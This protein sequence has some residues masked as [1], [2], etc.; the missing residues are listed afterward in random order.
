MSHTQI[1]EPVQV[2]ALYEVVDANQSSVHRKI[3]VYP[4]KKLKPLSFIWRQREYDVKDL[5]YVWH[6][7]KGE[8]DYYY[9]A[10][11]DGINI[12][13][14]VYNVKTFDWILNKIYCEG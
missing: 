2:Y 1:N 9:F 12:F 5:T 3:R 7:K 13:E 4:H 11:S 8:T 10:V 6:N 14:L